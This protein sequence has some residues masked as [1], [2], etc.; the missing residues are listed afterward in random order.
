MAVTQIYLDETLECG[1]DKITHIGLWDGDAGAELAGGT[2]AY[3]R[4]PVTWGAVV[5]GVRRPTTDLEF[6]IPPGSTVTGWRGFDALTN[7][8]NYGGGDFAQEEPFAGQG[9]HTLHADGTGIR[10]EVGS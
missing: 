9:E 7:G 8:T 3:A 5:A 6:D 2:P 4:Q 1:T 10:H